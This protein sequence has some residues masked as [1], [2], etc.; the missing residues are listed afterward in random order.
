MGCW[1]EAIAVIEAVLVIGAI[2]SAVFVARRYPAAAERWFNRIRN[3]KR[4]ILI[5]ITVLFAFVFI[6]SGVLP[7]MIIGAFSVAYATLLFI[8]ESP[9]EEV[10]EWIR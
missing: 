10:V 2:A 3:V 6:G 7:L 4:G 1:T 9:H 5:A 8:F